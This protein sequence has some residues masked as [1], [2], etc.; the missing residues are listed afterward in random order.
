MLFIGFKNEWA[1]VKGS[2]LYVGTHGQEFV[3]NQKPVNWDRMWVKT[4]NRDG[5]VKHLNWTDNYIKLRA[6][7]GIHFPGYMTHESCVWSNVH[8]R[9]FFL[10]RKASVDSYDSQEDYRKATNILLSATSNFEPSKIKVCISK[11]I[12]ALCVMN[13]NICIIC[14]MDTD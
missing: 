5:V 14:N 2:K 13:F 3:V 9:W 12:T 4:I 8:K 11:L 6:A 10:P 1:T 7:F